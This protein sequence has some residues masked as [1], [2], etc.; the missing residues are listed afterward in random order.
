[1]RP[2]SEK[3][4]WEFNSYPVKAVTRWNRHQAINSLI[5]FD[6]DRILDRTALPAAAEAGITHRHLTV[7]EARAVPC[8]VLQA[9]S[10]KQRKTRGD[11]MT[12]ERTVFGVI[13]CLAL[14]APSPGAADER[15]VHPKAGIF[16]TYEATD[17]IKG[18]KWIL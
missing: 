1:M 10:M 7:F 4:I 15:H 9:G 3:K 6:V 12:L 5:S 8:Q 16:W 2:I 13:A 14:I 11:E 18:N 17:E